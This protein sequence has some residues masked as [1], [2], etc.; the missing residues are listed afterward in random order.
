MSLALCPQVVSQAPQ[1]FRSLK[2]EAVCDGCF[3][4]QSI[5][6]V[7]SLHAGTSKAVSP[8]ELC[9]CHRYKKNLTGKRGFVYELGLGLGLCL[10][11]VSEEGGSK[12]K[13]GR[14]TTA[15]GLTD[16]Y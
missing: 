5:C 13:E 6:S 4:R 12:A 11:T 9:C 3:A 14:K 2:T 8:Q 16:K 1:H 10:L 7:I 15:L